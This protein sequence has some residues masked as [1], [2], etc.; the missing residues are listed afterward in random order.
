[1]R[2]QRALVTGAA[3][4]LG[5]R[6]VGELADTA[7]VGF[8]LARGAADIEWHE[9][10]V[11]DVDALARA[12]RNCDAVVHIA[13]IP[14]I[15]SGSEQEIMRANVLGTWNALRAAEKA[16]ARRFV[17][18]SSDSVVGFTVAAGRMLAPLY[19]PIDE[20]H[21]LRPTDAYA[22]SKK[23]GEEAARCFADRGMEVV[24][25]RPVFIAHPESMGEIRARA[26]DPSNYKPGAVGGRQPAGGGP[27]WH[28]I[29]PRDAARAF[30][31][32][33]ELPRVHF[34]VFFVSAAVTL[35]PEPTLERLQGYLRGS[36]PELRRPQLYRDNPHAPLY[37]LTRAREVLGFTPRY[38][39]RALAAAP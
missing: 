31:L 7:V 3:G 13:A 32:A 16:G 25:L 28:H 20:A 1:M 36:L 35:A 2:F 33:L 26:K 15:S 22:L 6:V 30:R 23:L 19:V 27:V 17:Y 12:V 5:S 10:N 39:A 11:L 37:D 21:P 29:D 8:D 14:N 4:L 38:D 18:C 9:G 24:V 34:E